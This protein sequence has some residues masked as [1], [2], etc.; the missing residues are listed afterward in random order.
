VADFVLFMVPVA[1]A[2]SLLKYAETELQLLFR[3]RLS[4]HL[5]DRYLRGQTYYQ[6]SLD[7]RAHTVDQLLTHDVEHLCESIVELYSDVLKPIFDIATYS[8]RLSNSMGT[9]APSTMV[10]YLL[11]SGGWMSSLRIPTGEF[12]ASTQRQE[13]EFRFVNSRF[14]TNTEEI[15]FYD[16][17]QREYG[18][19][20]QSFERLINLIRRSQQFRFSMNVLDST[21]AKYFSTVVGWLLVADPFIDLTNPTYQSATPDQ[22]YQNYHT[23]AKMMI[24]LAAALG[25]LILSGREFARLVGFAERIIEFDELLDGQPKENEEGVQ[26]GVPSGTCTIEED[27]IAFENVQLVSRHNM[28][29]FCARDKI[30]AIDRCVE[31]SAGHSHER[32]ADQVADLPD[33]EGHASD[34]MRAEWLRQIELV[35]SARRSVASTLRPCDPASAL[36]GT[37]Q[38]RMML[39]AVVILTLYCSLTLLARRPSCST[40]HRSRTCRW[41]RCAIK[42][43]TPT[44]ELT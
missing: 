23:K 10:G 24:N 12:T 25:R 13:G 39:D 42:S 31:L 28:H 44:P 14:A 30:A 4:R 43:S 26:D 21:F 8:W 40:C 1:C 11:L 19:I 20:W 29:F 37:S 6:L 34:D 35:P 22:L 33:Q 15:A 38:H 5:Y 7:P 36:S 18:A 2:T 27:M 3:T 41:D 16:G 17:A 32:S 9:V